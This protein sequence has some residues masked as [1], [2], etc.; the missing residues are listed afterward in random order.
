V[1][2]EN[3]KMNGMERWNLGRLGKDLY[4]DGHN[5]ARLAARYGTP[6]FVVSRKR[7]E[8]SF[9]QMKKAFL[10]EGLDVDVF[11]SFKT[12]PLPQA[13]KALTTCGVGAEIISEF[14]MWLAR[15]LG[16]GGDRILVN[17]PLKPRA[18]LDQAVECGARMINV[19]TTA[20]LHVLKE[21]AEKLGK[22]ANIGLRINPGLKKRRLQFTT[23]TGSSSSPMGFRCLS[24]EWSAALKLIKERRDLFQFRGL[25]FHIGTG[26]C[27]P[28]PYQEALT[29]TLGFMD[30][31][32]EN[33]L[34]PEILDIGGGF[35]IPTLKEINLWEAA[36]LFLWNRPQK[37]PDA[38]NRPNLLREVARA[39]A[40]QLGGYA[41]ARGISVPK[42]F[43]EPGRALS[44]PS[45]LLLLTVNSVRERPAG[46][47]S[48]FCDGGAMSLSQILI[49]EY[50]AIFVANK[51]ETGQL[52]KYNI[53]GS[54]PTPLD[55]VSFQ[56]RLSPLSRGDILAVMDTGA[57]FTS[58][59]N[60]FAGPRPA[61]VMLENGTS[62]LIRR[63]E[64]FEDLVARD[65]EF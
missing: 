54:L 25:H 9:E 41:K 4:W 31:L 10:A 63:R 47:S 11:F 19:E 13:L 28:A 51:P 56:R 34:S 14:E 58:L 64:T 21:I 39:C 30:S 33:G 42:I 53:F 12:N 22:K 65:I 46:P 26:I 2:N 43:I 7:L 8:R 45:Q 24:E 62:V 29:Q 17:G 61:V 16:L 3:P 50:H 52:K 5:L 1:E 37:P 44:G 40:H 48:V 59:G 49:S 57:Y 23:T 35:N 20:E 15:R 18:L 36:R 55:L 27:S 32:L 6:L 60:N 38:I